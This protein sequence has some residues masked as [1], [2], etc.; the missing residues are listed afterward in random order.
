MRSSPF[1]KPQVTINSKPFYISALHSQI[2]H[3]SPFKHIRPALP[4]PI[5]EE[6]ESTLKEECEEEV[7]DIKEMRKQLEAESSRIKEA[8]KASRTSNDVCVSHLVYAN[9]EELRSHSKNNSKMFNF[10]DVPLHQSLIQT[11]EHL[12]PLEVE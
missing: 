3:V 6:N 4:P 10:Q 8:L 2:I 7:K 5:Q 12:L 1:K 9:E 11:E